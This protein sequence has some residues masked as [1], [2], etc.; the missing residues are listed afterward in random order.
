MNCVYQVTLVGYVITDPDLECHPIDWSP[1]QLFKDMDRT[2][3]DVV[4]KEM[5]VSEPK[6]VSDA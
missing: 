2:Y 1:E 3:C 4:V 6:E 5:T